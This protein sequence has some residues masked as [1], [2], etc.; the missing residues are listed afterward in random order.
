MRTFD[1]TVVGAAG[2]A[3]VTVHADT[4][5]EACAAAA[6]H[7]EPVSVRRRLALSGRALT[8]Q[9][10]FTFLEKLGG[11]LRS[12]VGTGAALRLLRDQFS[13]RVREVA[14][15]LLA[16]I[17][18]GGDLCS[19]MARVGPKDFPPALVSIIRA[20]TQSGA[21]A[22]ALEAGARYEE[23]AQ[24]LRR[25]S[26]KGLISALV[27]YFAAVI[28]VGASVFWMGPKIMASPL[29]R[30]GD[31]NVDWAFTS[32]L[33]LT[34]LLGL[35]TAAL[36][37]L[38]INSTLLK[39]VAPLKADAVTRAIPVWRDAVLGK[40][41]FVAYHTMS[42]LLKTGMPLEAALSLASQSVPAGRLAQQLHAAA[43]FVVAG[44]PW[45]SQ[46]A[47]LSE[48]DRVAVGSAEDREQAALAFSRLSTFAR[49]DFVSSTENLVT[50]L[51]MTAAISLTLGGGLMFAL[52]ILPM[53][54][55]ASAIL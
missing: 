49:R 44:Q 48:L 17:E 16:D 36:I 1:V 20:G 31:T 45:V 47:D 8:S 46:L 14:S 5:A 9:E 24:T 21:T 53:L 12:Q 15:M 32:G 3:V 43:Q 55:A 51:Q 38:L 39:R 33:V 11:L 19:A 4:E 40:E 52:S 13:G 18:A 25:Q 28:V 50:G 27:G 29:L 10:R 22:D 37:G 41:R 23:D 34:A 2:E 7:G 26:R 54:M 6:E 35:L 42:A 30:A